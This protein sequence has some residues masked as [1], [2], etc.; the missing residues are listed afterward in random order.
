MAL[1]KDENGLRKV[2]L[3]LV[4]A[5]AVLSAVAGYYLGGTLH[6]GYK[7]EQWYDRLIYVLNNPLELYFNGKYTL[8]GI[9]LALFVYFILFLHYLTTGHNYMKGAEYGTSKFADNAK[10]NKKL[11]QPLDLKDENSYEKINEK[12][13]LNMKN[14][15]IT[16]HIHMSLN[17][18]FTDRNNNILVIGG[19][20]AGKTF[21]FVG[22]NLMTMS[23]SFICTDPKGEICRIYAPFLKK[24]GYK[25]KMINL[26]NA[27]EMKKSTHYN[28][29]KYIRS[30]TDI[31]K[32]VT[33]FFENTKKKDAQSGDQFWDDMA[34]LLLQAFFYYVRDIGVEMDGVLRHDFKAVM[35][36]VNMA[37]IEDDGRGG[38]KKTEL[39]YLFGEL[40]ME[41]PEH[42]A[43]ISYNKAMVGA[44]D[45]VRSIISTLNSR[46]TALQTDEILELLSDDEIDIPSIGTEKTALFCVI[47]D[48]DKTYNFMIGMLYSQIFQELYYQADFIYGGS[49]P[50]HVTFMLDEFANVALPDDYCSLLSTM[51]GRNISSIIIIQNMAQIKKLFDKSWETIPG[52][53]DTTIYLGGNELETHKYISELLG[54][55]TID[56]SSQSI[57]RG[58]N[59]NS[60]NSF[61][62]LGRELM[63]PDEV[64]RTDGTK[65]IVLIRGFNPV[66]DDKI[67]TLHLTYWQEV[68]ALSMQEVFDARIERAI[69]NTSGGG[70]NFYE[71][72]ELVARKAADRMA[73][74]EYRT[75]LKLYEIDPV[76]NKKPEKPKKSIIKINENEF[77]AVCKIIKLKQMFDEEELLK[78]AMKIRM[79]NERKAANDNDKQIEEKLSAVGYTIEQIT[80]LAAFCKENNIQPEEVIKRFPVTLA[81]PLI[82]FEIKLYAN[83]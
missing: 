46:T 59:G 74:D 51:R 20:G 68:C 23:S 5:G 67:D 81:A 73:E 16:Q 31:V 49:L 55:M 10:V 69:K 45:T 53:C 75:Q 27:D 42:L 30:D 28:P 38:R 13:Y 76:N 82:D 47:P 29:F 3:K 11:E 24:H 12:E 8:I 18:K 65:C 83:Q 7:F 64:R 80:I 26:L 43:V 50:V 35:K 39:D 41:H 36:L 14:R 6:A 32:L 62:V 22:P 77:I 34:G 19:S 17:T 60:S 4:I 61:D 37:K 9:S 57:S 25:I 56:K 72:K 79:Y 21:R 54:K 58:R 70:K 2:S 44:A 40:E 78:N 63:L 33:N 71:E 52:N 66:F 48:V 15:Q 1:Q